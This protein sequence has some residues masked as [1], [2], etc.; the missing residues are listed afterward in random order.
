MAVA[1]NERPTAYGSV[2]VPALRAAMNRRGRQLARLDPERNQSDREPTPE[3]E[4]DWERS[5]RIHRGMEQ[6]ADD[7]AQSFANLHLWD[8]EAPVQLGNGVD[9][10]LDAFLEEVLV[11]LQPNSL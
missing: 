5:V 9:A 3:E 4:K 7:I 1:E 2:I 6:M 8:A 11:R 10:I